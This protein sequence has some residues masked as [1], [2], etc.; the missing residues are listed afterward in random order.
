MKVGQYKVSLHELGTFRLDGGAMFGSV[1]KNLW[2]RLTPPDD[3]N[4]IR[5]TTRSMLLEAGERKILVDVGNGEKW[6]EKLRKIFAVENT[7]RSE[8]GFAPEE[9][10]DVLLTHLHFDHAGGIS[11]YDEKG[12]LRLSYPNARI[13]VQRENFEN[14]RN[15]IS[16]ERASYLKENVDI[17]LEAETIYL[18]GEV[19]PFPD[20]WV[21]PFH[22][23]TR[24]QQCVE[25]RGD[26]RVILFPTDLIPTAAHLPIPYNMGYDICAETLLK[27]KES[28]LQYALQKDAIVVFEHDPSLAA[29]KICLNEKGHYAVREEVDFLEGR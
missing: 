7:P 11:Y 16:R 5:L 25:V 22:G 12:K 27:E 14:A 29:A 26:D 3:D 2:S 18:E 21:K 8:L 24:G 10:T 13:Y 15:P 1:P 19:E 28:Y 6:N 17:L 23:H 20:I 4:C 9:I